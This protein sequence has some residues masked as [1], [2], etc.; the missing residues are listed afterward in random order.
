MINQCLAAGLPEPLFNY[1]TS[2]FWVVFRKDI[3]NHTQLKELG[4]NE[5]QIKAV[6]FVKDKG[7]IT[8]SIYQ[9]INNTKQTLSSQEL[10]ELVEKG[11]LRSSGAKGRGAK[12]LLSL[13]SGK[14]I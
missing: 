12:Y 3:Y 2:G 8:N 6:L 1:E 5:R 9:E 7:E 14:T 10:S 13:L 11:I 4:L